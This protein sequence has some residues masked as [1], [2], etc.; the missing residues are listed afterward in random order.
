MAKVCQVVTIP[1][2][3]YC[4]NTLDSG[5]KIIANHELGGCGASAGARLSVDRLKLMGFSSEKVVQID[6]DTAE[7]KAAL[8]E[9]T[10]EGT[11]SALSGP[12]FASSSRTPRG[13][14]RLPRSSL[15]VSNYSG[16]GDEAR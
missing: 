14:R 7:G 16:A 15:A 10:K 6:L 12:P 8:V 3:S 5:E 2:G 1:T 9:L 13:A 4:N 11:P